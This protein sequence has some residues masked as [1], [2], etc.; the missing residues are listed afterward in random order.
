MGLN[1]TFKD[2]RAFHKAFNHPVS[3]K[4]VLIAPERAKARHA[5]LQE[6]L[7]EFIE[8]QTIADQADA[9]I[10]TIYFAVGTLVEMGISAPQELFDIVQNANMAK[11]W[12]DGK[13][14]YNEMNKVIKPEGW[15]DPEHKLLEAIA[16][17]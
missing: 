5:W 9:M 4:P 1:K 2:V 16:K 6:E 11:L 10:D 3:D 12:P 8:A 14:R 13:P 17:M 15:E 7:D